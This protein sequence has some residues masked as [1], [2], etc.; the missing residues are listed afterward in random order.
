MFETPGLLAKGKAYEESYSWLLSL[1]DDAG[2]TGEQRELVSDSKVC[3]CRRA[4]K[5][6]TAAF[7]ANEAG[8]V[9]RPIRLTEQTG[10]LADGSA[11]DRLTSVGCEIIEDLLANWRLGWGDCGECEERHEDAEVF[12]IDLRSL[13]RLAP[14]I[15]RSK[16]FAFLGLNCF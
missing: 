12:H 11:D 15:E 9:E 5:T 7:N 4:D 6:S 8:N 16:R 13:S 14:F 10:E 3:R 2:W 1:S